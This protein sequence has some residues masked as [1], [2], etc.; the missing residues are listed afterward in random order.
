MRRLVDEAGIQLELPG[1]GAGGGPAT[2]SRC[3]RP[4]GRAT[5]YIAVH[6]YQ[7]TPHDQ[8]FQGVEAIMDRYGGRPHWGKMHFQ[9]H[10]TLAE[11]YPRWDEFQAVRR[12]PRPRRPVHQPVPRPGARPVGG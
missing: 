9:S 5:G 7:G 8:Y 10:E 12:P 4:T 11:R 6:V 1:G 2:T 3:P